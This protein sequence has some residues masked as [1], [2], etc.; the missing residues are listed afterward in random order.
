MLSFDYTAFV[1]VLSVT[2]LACALAWRWLRSPAERVFFSLLAGGLYFYCGIGGALVPVA[3][4]YLTTYFCFLFVYIATFIVTLS[5]ARH[6]LSKY[7]SAYRSI[8][9]LAFR[10]RFGNVVRCAYLFACLVPLMYPTVRLAN[11]WNPPHP[12][13]VTALNMGLAAEVPVPLRLVQYCNY[14]LWPLYTISLYQMRR[15]YV[16]LSIFTFIPIYIQYC[17]TSYVGRYTILTCILF[18][19]LTTWLDRPTWHQ[20]IVIGTLALLPVLLTS[21]LAY[22]YQRAGL[23]APAMSLADSVEAL[24]KIEVTFPENFSKIAYSGRRADP[25]A[26]AIWL[27]S[28]PIPKVLTG[29]IPGA[30]INYEIANIITGVSVGQH[31]FNVPLAGPVCESI[32]I[33]G[34]AWYWLHAIFIGVLAGLACAFATGCRALTP[35]LIQLAILFGLCFGRAGVGGTYAFLVNTYLGAYVLMFIAI[36]RNGVPRPLR[37]RHHAYVNERQ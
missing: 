8:D 31:N 3:L 9:E 26:Y 23:D 10:P 17:T 18:V 33:Y 34:P 30:R 24:L 11:L 7:R 12:D 27:L 14:I 32:Y 37:I 20:R 2:L 1:A 22:Q 4:G 13:I 5:A 35:I 19:L 6:V 15:R 16:A 28:T 36:L 29:E 21:A 25:A